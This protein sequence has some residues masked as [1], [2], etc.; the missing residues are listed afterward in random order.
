MTE[1]W[2]KTAREMVS[3]LAKGEVRPVEALDAAAQRIEA[4][5]GAVNAM[6]TV[7]LERARDAAARIEA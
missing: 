5:N 2:R 4:T 1:L 7:C 3:L 6:V